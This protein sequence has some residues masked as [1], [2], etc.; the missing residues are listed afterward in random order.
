MNRITNFRYS[1]IAVGLLLLTGLISCTPSNKESKQVPRLPAQQQNQVQ[2][3]SGNTESPASATI[4]NTEQPQ[5]K[6]NNGVMLNP[7]HGQPGHRC[8]IPVGAPLNTPAANPVQQPATGGTAAAAPTIR[9][10]SMSPTIEN[11]NRIN[12]SQTRSSAAPETGPKPANNPP[13]GQPWHRCDIAVGSP[14]P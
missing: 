11:A 3:N 9:S 8:E 14:L 7:P 4:E 12:P 5:N 10:N 2:N 6:N 13:H 1:F